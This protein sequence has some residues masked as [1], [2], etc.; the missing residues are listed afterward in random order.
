MAPPKPKDPPVISVGPP[1][2]R[3]WGTIEMPFTAKLP[4]GSYNGVASW[5]VSELSSRPVGA[6]ILHGEAWAALGDPTAWQT[7]H[8]ALRGAIERVLK[9]RA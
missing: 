6:P 2:V 8:D 3:D 9:D 5:G 1:L 4:G 7:T